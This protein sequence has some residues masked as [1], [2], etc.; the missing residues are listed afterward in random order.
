MIEWSTCGEKRIK[1]VALYA[2][3]V[4]FSEDH[5]ENQVFNPKTVNGLAGVAQDLYKPFW[6][7]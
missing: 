4:F 2:A 3:P 1:A 6:M 7:P 5:S